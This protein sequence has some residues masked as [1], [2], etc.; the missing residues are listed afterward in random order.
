LRLSAVIEHGDA[1]SE[2]DLKLSS[3][4]ENDMTKLITT[5]VLALGIVSA[6][7]TAN[8]QPRYGN[9]LAEIAATHSTIT[10]HGFWD[11]Q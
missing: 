1:G 10:P 5:F 2:N 3:N 6:A 8:A 11:A 9:A 4:P 7:A